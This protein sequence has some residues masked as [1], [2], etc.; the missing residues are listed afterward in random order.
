MSILDSIP[1][2][3]CHDDQD[4]VFLAIVSGFHTHFFASFSACVIAALTPPWTLASKASATIASGSVIVK[5]TGRPFARCLAWRVALVSVKDDAPVNRKA[6]FVVSDKNSGGRGGHVC[7]SVVGKY[8][9]H[10]YT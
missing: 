2:A 8:R 3:A 9:I 4:V 6:F 7:V 10:R 1:Q 5:L